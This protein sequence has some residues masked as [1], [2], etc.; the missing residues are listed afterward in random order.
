MDDAIF[1]EDSDAFVAEEQFNGS[2]VEGAILV[3]TYTGSA[4]KQECVDHMTELRLLADTC[5]VT[6]AKEVMA[7]MRKRS[8]STFLGKGKVEELLELKEELGADLFIFDDEILPSQQRNL[9]KILKCPVI[10]RTEVILD[11]FAQRAQTREAKLQIAL[12]Q[13]QYQFPRLKRMWTH[14]SRQVGGGLFVKGMGEKQIEIDKR[15]LQKKRE[16]LEHDLKQIRKTR[17]TQRLARKR[18]GIPVFA[19]VGY[20][21]VGKSTLLNKLTE[22]EVLVEDKLFATLDT[23][24]R[25]FMLPNNQ[26]VLLID[27]VGFIRKLPHHL[28]EAFKS[29]LEESVQADILLHLIDATHPNA[30]DQAEATLDVL[31]QLGASGKTILTVLNKIDRIEDRKTLHKWRIKFHHTL[32]ISAETGEGLEEMLEVMMDELSKRRNLMHLKIPQEDYALVGELNR[33]ANVIDQDYEGNDVLVTAEVPH[34][35]AHKVEKY[36]VD[37]EML[38]EGETV[39]EDLFE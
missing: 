21:N 16:N 8:A 12:A 32:F 14:L 29:T 17:E 7:P 4:D 11:V 6:I 39:G 5:G 27:T 2:R 24:T 9:E 37:E 10:D 28:I 19:F 15:L 1:F 18:S 34:A 13:V 25:K 3:G 38:A 20:T 22:S 31:N 35:F 36:L 30:L 26:N 33:L 23:T